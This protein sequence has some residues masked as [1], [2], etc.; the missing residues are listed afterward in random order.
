MIRRPPRSTLFPTRRSSDLDS[1]RFVERFLDDT[2]PEQV[3]PPRLLTGDDLLAMGYRPGPRF[4]Q[5]L[6]GV[7]DAQLEGQ[8]RTEEEAKEYVLRNFGAGETKIGR[9]HV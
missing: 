8:I 1:Y 4:A 7:E 2:P 9:A 5:I 3:R 6:R